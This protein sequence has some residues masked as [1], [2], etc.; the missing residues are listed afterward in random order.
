MPEATHVAY[1]DE[2]SYNVGR[3]RGIGLVT[4]RREEALA[5]TGEFGRLLR[6]GDI[7]ELKW[8]RLRGARERDVALKMLGL[9]VKKASA[10][11]LR[12]DILIWDTQD[13][14]HAVKG[15]DDLANLQRMYYQLLKNVLRERWPDGSVWRLHPDE[16]TGIDWETIGGFLELAGMQVEDVGLLDAGQFSLRIKKEFSI[17]RIVPCRSDVEPLVQLADLCGG[18]GVYSREHYGRYEHWLN[19]AGPQPPLFGSSTGASAGLG[20]ADWARC[21]LL[22]RFHGLCKGQKLGVGLEG[23]RGLRTRN[24]ARPVNFW[25]YQPQS[26][27]D[28]APTKR[29]R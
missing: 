28:K 2:T 25:W 14:R 7:S 29:A 24:P 10:G 27:R 4:A 16:Q 23:S 9:A 12:L 1:S 13:S 8:E 11:L 18:L 17:D 5:L 3:F 19:A 20:R 6:D 26:E 21:E 15:R 22:H